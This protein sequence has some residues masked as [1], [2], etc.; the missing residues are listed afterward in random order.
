MEW[1]TVTLTD[2]VAPRPGEP[3]QGPLNAL[4]PRT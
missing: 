1:G 2:L 3:D 4:R